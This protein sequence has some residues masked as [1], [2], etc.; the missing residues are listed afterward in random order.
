MHR[1]SIIGP[2]VVLGFTT[3]PTEGQQATAPHSH[4]PADGAYKVAFWY[5][6]DQPVTS[7]K[8]QAYNLAKGEYDEKAVDRWFRSILDHDPNHGAYIRDIQTTG[9]PGATEQERLASAIEHEKG[10][11]AALHRKLS[12]PLPKLNDI[13]PTYTRTSFYRPPLSSPGSPGS[14]ITPGYPGVYS[15][16]PVSPFPYPYRSGPR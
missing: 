11:W 9:F 14:P 15:N 7:L 2:I 13:S 10:R 4:K 1:F 16:P 6:A 3:A 12:P 8:Y 5:E